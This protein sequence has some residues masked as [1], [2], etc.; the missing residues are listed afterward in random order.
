MISHP[1]LIRRV[2]SMVK[3]GQIAAGIEESLRQQ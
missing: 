2:A 3:A 1:S